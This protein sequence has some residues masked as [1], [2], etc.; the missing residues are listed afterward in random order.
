M[1]KNVRK[2]IG[3]SLGVLLLAGCQGNPVSQS[4]GHLL[5]ASD[6]SSSLLIEE[7]LTGMASGNLLSVSVNG[8]ND[9]SS[10]K[11]IRYRLSWRDA[12]GIEIQGLPSNWHSVDL[13]PKEPFSLQMVASSPEATDYRVYIYNRNSISSNMSDTEALSY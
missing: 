12:S 10:T 5:I 7:V 1:S 11:F 8:F 3:I 13:L 4:G 9:S 6:L 2:I